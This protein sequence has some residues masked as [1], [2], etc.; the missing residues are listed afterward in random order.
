MTT[1]FHLK[2]IDLGKGWHAD[3]T[4]A[5]MYDSMMVLGYMA[6]DEGR[7]VLRVLGTSTV[8]P[9]VNSYAQ[10]ALVDAIDTMVAAWVDAHASTPIDAEAYVAK[11]KARAR[12]EEAVAVSANNED[13]P[14]AEW[15]DRG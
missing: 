12:F 5:W 13:S 9:Y 8:T 3:V 4:I 10:S 15:K 11:H 7:T 6:A 14:D 1:R 2:N